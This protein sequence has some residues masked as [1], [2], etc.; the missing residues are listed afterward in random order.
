MCPFQQS[1][2]LNTS[3]S[4]GRMCRVMKLARST[5][6]CACFH[7]PPNSPEA[8]TPLTSR[9]RWGKFDA[10]V[11]GAVSGGS[12]AL[13]SLA[14]AGGNRASSPTTE[15]RGIGRDST[16][17]SRNWIAWPIKMV[18][19]FSSRRL[20]PGGTCSSFTRTRGPSGLS[21]WH[22]WLSSLIA[23][24]FKVILPPDSSTVHIFSSTPSPS[25]SLLFDSS[26]PKDR[27]DPSSGITYVNVPCKE[28]SS[29][30]FIKYG[31]PDRMS[32]KP[33]ARKWL[34]LFCRCF[35]SVSRSSSLFGLSVK[36]C[37]NC[38]LCLISSIIASIAAGS[39]APARSN[40]SCLVSCSTCFCKLAT[41]SSL[42]TT[43]SEG[44]VFNCL[45]PN[46]NR[47]VANVSV[48]NS[49]DGEIVAISQVLEFP[50]SEGASSMVSLELR[51]SLS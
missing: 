31:R 22:A 28:K 44:L 34:V 29:F 8:S 20:E 3:L 14:T 7:R 25:R 9:R 41:I 13:I 32:A 21:S 42:F 43:F 45:Q 36:C 40:R 23:T 51:K 15:A 12:K 50:V 4:W 35:C 30:R 18:S 48:V 16:P 1:C 39:P 37:A 46:A 17:P 33:R 47:S 24:T 26:V 49:M 19:L 10:L 11:L 38:L 5:S 6:C 2:R 27:A